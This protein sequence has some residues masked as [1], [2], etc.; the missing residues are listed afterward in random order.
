MSKQ[1]RL[2]ISTAVPNSNFGFAK[3][4]QQL[5][6]AGSR[7]LEGM[8]ELKAA[9]RKALDLTRAQS[10]KKPSSNGSVSFE[11]IDMLPCFLR[12]T[13]SEAL[14]AGNNFTHTAANHALAL[15]DEYG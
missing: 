6:N 3:Y 8:V 10:S 2:R 4:V 14:F 9:C 15:H 7:V 11:G 1:K 5:K 12:F 13:C